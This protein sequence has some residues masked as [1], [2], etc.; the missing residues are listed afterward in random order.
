[1]KLASSLV[2]NVIVISLALATAA[3]NGCSS[4]ETGDTTGTPGQIIHR[5]PGDSGHRTAHILAPTDGSPW[6]ARLT[7]ATA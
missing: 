7:P 3:L 1:M 2:T 6:M 4:D 5:G